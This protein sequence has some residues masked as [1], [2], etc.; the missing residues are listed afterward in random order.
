MNRYS[1]STS[2]LRIY[3]RIGKNMFSIGKN[4]NLNTLGILCIL[5]NFWHQERP[6]IFISTIWCFTQADNMWNESTSSSIKVY[7][8][9]WFHDEQEAK[10]H[11][12][13]KWLWACTYLL[14]G[15]LIFRSYWGQVV[16]MDFSSINFDEL[17]K[18][19]SFPASWVICKED[20][21][22]MMYYHTGIYFPE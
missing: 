20:A 8:K 2:Y 14:V 22:L 17:L 11:C 7:I 19:V 12:D 21:L 16:E 13:Q 5:Q 18:I 3:Q 6:W 4:W 9:K 15:D 1:I 10:F